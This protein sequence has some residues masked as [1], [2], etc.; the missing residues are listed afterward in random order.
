M[1]WQSGKEGA[2]FA[3]SN[4]LEMVTVYGTFSG[5][6]I[7]RAEL[8]LAGDIADGGGHRCYRY[9]THV[10]DDRAAS[11]DN[12]RSSFVR[13][14]EGVPPYFTTPH[15]HHPILALPAIR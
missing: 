14:F 11:K 3:L 6:T 12:Y 8:N 13:F 1:L 4:G 2:Y 10:I 5:H 9:L 15:Y 7:S